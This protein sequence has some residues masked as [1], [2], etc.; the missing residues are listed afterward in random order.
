MELVEGNFAPHMAT[1]DTHGAT[2][3]LTFFRNYASSQFA[4]PPVF[5]HTTQQ[6]GDVQAVSFCPA[7]NY[8]NVVGNV[9][10]PAAGSDPRSAVDLQSLHLHRRVRSLRPQLRTQRRHGKPLVPDRSAPRQLRHG[11]PSRDVGLCQRPARPAGVAL[12]HDEAGVVACQQ[13]MAVGWAGSGAHG[14]DAA[15]QGSVRRHGAV[16]QDRLQR[17]SGTP[18]PDAPHPTACR[19]PIAHS[20]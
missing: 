13:P 19:L 11:E 5:G 4:Y 18:R 12:P 3:Y 7:C 15:G 14:R 8:M 20:S 1:P 9:L 17:P 16:A 6:S 10:G 2:G